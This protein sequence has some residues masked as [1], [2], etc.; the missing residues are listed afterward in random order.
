[1]RARARLW[2]AVVTVVIGAG[3]RAKATA[4]A[5]EAIGELTVAQ[6]DEK[7]PQPNVF[8]FDNNPREVW[9]SG[10][11]PGARWLDPSKITGAD[12]PPDKSA[13]LIFYCANEH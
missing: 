13:T 2:V 12:L 7:R 9:A 10:H 5:T 4:E 11:L 8:L 6:V 1:M 3:C